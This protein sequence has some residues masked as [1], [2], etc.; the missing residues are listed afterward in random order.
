MPYFIGVKDTNPRGWCEEV[1]SE[2]KKGG[3]P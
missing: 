3:Q 2:I 1:E